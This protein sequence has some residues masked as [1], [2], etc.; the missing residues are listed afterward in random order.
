MQLHNASICHDS[1]LP[2]MQRIRI[3][4]N[5]FHRRNL[6]QRQ[7]VL[8]QNHDVSKEIHQ[9]QC[10]WLD[11]IEYKV[12]TSILYGWSV[13]DCRC[14][15]WL[16]TRIQHQD[17]M[18]SKG[19]NYLPRHCLQ[20]HSDSSSNIQAACQYGRFRFLPTPAFADG[21]EATAFFKHVFLR[22]KL[23]IYTSP[24]FH[25][26]LQIHHT[27][28]FIHNACRSVTLLAGAFGVDPFTVAGSFLASKGLATQR[29]QCPSSWKSWMYFRS[30]SLQKLRHIR[31]FVW[32]LILSRFANPKETVPINLKIMYFRSTSL[33]NLRK[34]ST[35]GFRLIRSK[36][37]KVAQ[38]S[39]IF[40]K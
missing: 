7:Q 25:N 15:K 35:F 6:S 2:H 29:R 19:D 34:I 5:T 28:Q 13:P 26:V 8:L 3:Q 33:Q 18:L 23:V 27:I 24:C 36:K 37:A 21:L 1:S 32:L 4:T 11:D 30:T 12:Y 14:K 40:E 17:R 31:T 39:K 22:I 38:V 20:K 10:H 9:R 16:L